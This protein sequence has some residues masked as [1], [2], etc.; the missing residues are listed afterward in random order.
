MKS[1]KST[2]KP[3]VGDTHRTVGCTDGTAAT[4]DDEFAQF[5]R[6]AARR[7]GVDLTGFSLPAQ[8]PYAMSP[9]RAAQIAVEAGIITRSGKLRYP[10]K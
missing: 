8:N 6:S 5:V 3:L 9:E 7:F 10:F 4:S 2:A 1:S